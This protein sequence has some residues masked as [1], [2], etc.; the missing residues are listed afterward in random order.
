MVAQKLVP[1][2]ITGLHHNYAH[3]GLHYNNYATFLNERSSG[4]IAP[5]YNREALLR[6]SKGYT[7]HKFWREEWLE[8]V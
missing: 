1:V 8:L 6:Y 2:K 4:A 3:K 7:T 5:R